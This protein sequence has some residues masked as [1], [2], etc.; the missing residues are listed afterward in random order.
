MSKEKI[1]AA[2]ELIMKNGCYGIECRE[3][4]L[5]KGHKYDNFCL[6]LQVLQPD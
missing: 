3:C 5:Y 1:I 4:P 2:I 6:E